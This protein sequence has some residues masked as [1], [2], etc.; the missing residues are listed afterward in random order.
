MIVWVLDLDGVLQ[1]PLY[2]HPRLISDVSSVI[3]RPYEELY[4]HYTLQFAGNEGE[5]AYH[6]SLCNNKG[7]KEKV[8]R[9]WRKLHEK[10]LMVKVIPGARELL[11]ELV[12]RRGPIFAWTKGERTEETQRKRLESIG[13]ARFFR[14][15]HIIS[16]PQKGT[17][18]GLEEDL[19]PKLP[20][21]QKILVG[22]RFRQDI[23]PALNREDVLCVWIK[24][25]YSDEQLPEISERDYLNLRIVN[26]LREL[27][28]LVNEG[29]FDGEGH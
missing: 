20:A 14:Q 22:D 28:G 21:G 18:E 16:S 27:L 11:E 7:Q 23:E 8:R 9:Y 2:P 24:E 25:S 13:L 10:M 6:L 3:G 1:E 4:A 15:G 5:E 26:D 19:L 17:S 12:A 29:V